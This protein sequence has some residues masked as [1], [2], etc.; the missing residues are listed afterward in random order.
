MTS[1]APLPQGLRTT[2][3]VV[4]VQG[5][6]GVLRGGLLMFGA[7]AYARALDV[8]G[9]GGVILFAAVGALVVLISVLVIRAGRLLGRRSRAARRGVL[10]F[11]YLSIAF[12]ILSYA[13]P[14]QA[15]ITVVLAAIA[16]YNLQFQAETRAVFAAPSAGA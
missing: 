9:T 12:G 14:W 1:A 5:G 8:R 6:L 3:V 7:A 16:I 13:D 2:R 4:Y 10:L 15:G 11:E